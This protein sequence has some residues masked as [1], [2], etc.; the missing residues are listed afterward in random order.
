MMCSLRAYCYASFKY[1]QIYT[2]NAI[3]SLIDDFSRQFYELVK[4]QGV[5]HNTVLFYDGFGADTRGLHLIYLKALIELNYHVVYVTTVSAKERQ[6]EV[7]QLL[8]KK[9]TLLYF[10]QNG[11]NKVC[12][13]NRNVAF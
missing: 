7:K 6:K 8:N 3:E 9:G 13:R 2:D 1:N 10:D 4:I 11:I 5:R 12:S